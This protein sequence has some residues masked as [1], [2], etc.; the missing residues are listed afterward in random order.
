[1]ST[2]KAA[3][4]SQALEIAMESFRRTRLH[5]EPLNS[6][7]GKTQSLTAKGVPA[8]TQYAVEIEYM[9]QRYSRLAGGIAPEKR[10][11]CYYIDAA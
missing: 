11:A 2:K 9:G 7:V 5:T 6:S 4:E 3:S 8:Y 10:S 1:M